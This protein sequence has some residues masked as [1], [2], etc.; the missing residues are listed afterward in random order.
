MARFMI[1]K[2]KHAIS[3][4]LL[5]ALAA[6]YM[7]RQPTP[8]NINAILMAFQSLIE[9]K[10][11]ECKAESTIVWVFDGTPSGSFPSETRVLVR[12][13]NF[14]NFFNC[15]RKIRIGRFTF[16]IIFGHDLDHLGLRTTREVRVMICSGVWDGL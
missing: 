4:L 7:W 15:W 9:S 12:I 16:L 5:V 2:Q 3:A 1:L 10:A 11:L 14:F 13:F 6:K 8:L